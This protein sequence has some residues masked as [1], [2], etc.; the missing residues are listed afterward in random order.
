MLNLFVSR[1]K[2]RL[3]HLIWASHIQTT[4]LAVHAELPLLRPLACN[5]CQRCGAKVALGPH[6]KWPKGL[7]SLSRFQKTHTHMDPYGFCNGR[8]KKGGKR[9]ACQTPNGTLQRHVTS[10]SNSDIWFAL[11]ILKPLPGSFGLG[12]ETIN[13]PLA[14]P[15]MLG[16]GVPKPPAHCG[17]RPG[18]RFFFQGSGNPRNALVGFS[19]IVAFQPRKTAAL[20]QIDGTGKLHC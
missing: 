16:G 15:G 4:G 13:T 11:S 19:P 17:G 10:A 20:K 9:L 6:G 7:A 2:H 12:V 1:F 18:C 3:E 5:L 14:H 8:C